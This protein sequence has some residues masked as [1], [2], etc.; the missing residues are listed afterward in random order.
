MLSISSS[1]IAATYDIILHKSDSRIQLLVNPTPLTDI[2]IL[3]QKTVTIKK[4]QRLN[5]LLSK[6]NNETL[7]II[8]VES[9]LDLKDIC[10]QLETL[11]YVSLA[12]PNYALELYQEALDPLSFKQHYLIEDDLF[13]LWSLQSKRDVVIA[14]IDTGVNLNHE[15]LKDAIYKN[16]GELINGKDDDGNGYIDDITGYQWLDWLGNKI[17]SHPEDDHGHGTHMAGIIAGLSNQ[18]GIVGIH[19]GAKILPLKVFNQFGIGYQLE[20]ALAIRYAVDQGASIINCSWGFIFKTKVLEDAVEYAL[21]NDVIV[22]AAVGNNSMKTVMYPARFKSVIGVGSIEK[23][24]KQLESFS[25]QG[26]GLDVAISGKD[27]FSTSLNNGYAH[28]SGTS[29]STAIISGILGRIVSYYPNLTAESYQSILIQSSPKV[30]PANIR[31]PNVYALLE[32]FNIKAGIN[33]DVAFYGGSSKNT[34]ISNVMVAPNPIRSNQAVI[35]FSAQED[36]LDGYVT[37]YNL[38]GVLQKKK[39]FITQSLNSITLNIADMVN[40]TY[41]YTVT[42]NG[43]NEVHKGKCS[44]LR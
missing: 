15:D 14:I 28:L 6:N 10:D 44:I 19:P 30:L 2:T 40:G 16:E 33:A 32:E 43:L 35:Y 41:L 7:D 11:P 3:K 24:T 12:E 29:T 39:D 4:K 5:F 23:A 38:E 8:R 25:N 22:V 31:V 21:A 18:K 26:H 17:S 13:Q 1:L 20:A 34:K 37:F 9:S 42:L 27:V 36:G